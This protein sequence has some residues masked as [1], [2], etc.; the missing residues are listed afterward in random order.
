MTDAERLLKELVEAL[1]DTYWSSWQGTYKF[2]P[3]LEKA[4]EYL[5]G[6]VESYTYG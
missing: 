4:R 6:C 2:D 1:D 3:A 5:L